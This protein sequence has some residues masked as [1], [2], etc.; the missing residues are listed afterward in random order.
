MLKY[1]SVAFTY[2]KVLVFC[3]FIF[4]IGRPCSNVILDDSKNYYYICG[5]SVK[6]TN[7]AKQNILLCTCLFNRLKHI[8]A[9]TGFIDNFI[10]NL[11]TKLAGHQL[12]VWKQNVWDFFKLQYVHAL[13][14]ISNS[15]E[16]LQFNFSRNT[17]EN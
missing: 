15:F 8:S 5:L 10:L 11:I 4:L 2:T 1:I 6:S 3:D 12:L 13:N 17:K 14:F 9:K 16:V 7:L